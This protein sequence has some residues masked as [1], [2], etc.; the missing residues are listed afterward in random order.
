LVHIVQI[1]HDPRSTI[2]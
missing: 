2:H 1:Y